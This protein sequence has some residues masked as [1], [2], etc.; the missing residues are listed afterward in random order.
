MRVAMLILFCQAVT[1]ALACGSA[2]ALRAENRS[3]FMT[4]S[5]PRL[6]VDPAA[7]DYPLLAA[8]IFFETNER[9]SQNGLE[10]LEHLPEL[11][12]AACLHAEAMV[13]RD[14]FG[15]LN[16][17]SAAIRTPADRVRRQ[18][19]E[20]RFLAEN[21]GEVLVLRYE[22]G[23]Q[24]YLRQEDGRTAFSDEPGGEPLGKRS[25]L[26]IAE[27]IVDSWML[28]PGHRRN[29]LASEAELFGAGCQ[30]ESSGEPGMPLFTCVQLFFSPFD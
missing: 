7:V 22:S 11:D 17:Y 20:I 13:E 26:E 21:I 27:A 25:Y 16:P 24:V 18:G 23:E 29:I 12:E 4:G 1:L 3:Q 15:H 14:F 28:S 19:L 5:E 2:R 8:A 9:R 6:P 30:L 10:P